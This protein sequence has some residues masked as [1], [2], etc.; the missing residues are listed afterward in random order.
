[1]VKRTGPTNPLTRMRIRALR[2]ASKLYAA[3]IWRSV[4][5]MLE[6]PTRQRIEVNLSRINRYTKKGDAVIVPGKVL[7]SGELD[8]P[9]I[10]A[11]LSFSKT[12]YKKITEV[13]GEALTLEEALKRFPNGSRV[14][15]IG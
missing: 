5:E 11:A 13:G 7:G 14:K 2:K 8:H 12:A 3:P 1:M 9:V 4:A 10:V 6:R 15:I